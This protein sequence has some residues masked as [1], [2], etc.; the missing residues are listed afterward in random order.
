M[1]PE[2]LVERLNE[3]L[4]RWSYRATNTGLFVR[5]NDRDVQ[6]FVNYQAAKGL[7]WRD[8]EKAIDKARDVGERP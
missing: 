3:D 1:T 7:T 6:I 2:A 8:V 5:D 4:T